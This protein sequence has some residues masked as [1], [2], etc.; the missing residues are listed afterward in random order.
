MI[1]IEE[2]GTTTP[3]MSKLD[4]GPKVL[5]ITSDTVEFPTQE[6]KEQVRAPSNLNLSISHMPTTVLQSCTLVL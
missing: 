3:I 5:K 6:I 1:L 4:N 2:P